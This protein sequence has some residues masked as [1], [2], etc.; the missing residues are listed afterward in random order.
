MGGMEKKG[1]VCD[2]KHHSVKPIMII[3]IGI[4]ILLNAFAIISGMITMVIIGAAITIT[5]IVKLM[6]KKCGCCK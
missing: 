2:C 4:A 6:G 1:M 5:G 3:I